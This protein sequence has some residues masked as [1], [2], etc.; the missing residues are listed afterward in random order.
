MSINLGDAS[1][2]DVHNASQGFS[3]WT[4]ELRG[5]GYNWFFVMP[6]V[7]GRRPDGSTFSGIAI[8]L[9]YGV[10]I[11]WDGRVLQHCTSLSHPDGRPYRENPAASPR[12]SS[13]G[14]QRFRNHLYGNFSSAKERI[15]QAGR[16]RSAGAQSIKR[17]MEVDGN[18]EE[19]VSH[20]ADEAST[21]ID[22]VAP[23]LKLMNVGDYSIPKKRKHR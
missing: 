4:E 2:Y 17:V 5:V 16:A 12:V 22:A 6:N 3:I 19:A 1:H 7:Y 20:D 11:S 21:A 9:L 8:K 13:D 23:F 14:K 18:V 15:V 10:A